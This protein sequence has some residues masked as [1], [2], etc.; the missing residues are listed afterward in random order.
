MYAC[1]RERLEACLVCLS[2]HQL[3]QLRRILDADLNDPSLAIRVVI[4]Q[5]RRSVQ[6]F[7]QL[8]HLARYRH[9]QVADGL[10]S[11]NGSEDLTLTYR[12]AYCRHVDK[13]DLA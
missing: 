11:L 2:V 12:L 6:L 3:I 5:L 7:V 8:Q 10:H 13:D 1:T 9:I 4:N